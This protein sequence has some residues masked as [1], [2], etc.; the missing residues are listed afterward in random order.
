MST[1]QHLLVLGSPRSG[2]T[3]LASMLGHHTE[4]GM[5]NECLDFGIRYPIGSPISANKLCIPNQ[6]ELKRRGHRLVNIARRIGSVGQTTP[7]QRIPWS[8]FSIQDHINRLDD[9]RFVLIIRDGDAV[10][11]SMI[12]RGSKS[13]ATALHWWSRSIEV[14]DELHSTFPDRCLVLSFSDLVNEAEIQMRRVAHFLD[15]PFQER[16]LEG[17][18]FNP[19]YPGRKSIDKSKADSAETFNLHQRVPSVV[20]KY[21]TLA[22]S[23]AAHTCEWLEEFQPC[24]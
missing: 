17:Y 3:L 5:V 12:K 24:S 9:L 16:M 20:A 21:R 8:C 1:K 22:D 18:R 10:I 15:I 11:S 23:S 6:I 19:T 13:F 4:I 14:I 7:M 2:T